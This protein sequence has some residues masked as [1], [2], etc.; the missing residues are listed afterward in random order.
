LADLVSGSRA[1]LHEGRLGDRRGGRARSIRSAEVA[2]I[3]DAAAS[4]QIDGR[5]ARARSEE[6]WLDRV[7]GADGDY[8]AGLRRTLRVR[9][10]RL[11]RELRLRG[12][13][14]IERARHRDPES[15]EDGA[16]RGASQLLRPQDRAL[17]AR[18]R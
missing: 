8:V 1:L 15:G 2:A 6:T 11:L 9:A 16:L 3:P 12:A 7:S 14:Q 17:I 18:A 13:R 5:S 10:V 4:A